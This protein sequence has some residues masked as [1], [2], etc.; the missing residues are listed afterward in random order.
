M[1]D[2]NLFATTLEFVDQGV[3]V[4]D[5]EL[6]VI[7]FNH[8]YMEL[9][10]FPTERFEQGEPLEKFIRFNAERG[11]Y[12]AGDIDDL[13]NARIG[14]ARTFES[15]TS[16]R[17]RPD[18]TVLKLCGKPVPGGGFIETYTDITDSRRNETA[19]RNNKFR[20]KDVAETSYDRLWETDREFRYT[21]ITDRRGAKTAP[22]IE[23][24]IGQT[25]WELAGVDVDDNEYW[26]R[27]YERLV[28]HRPF[29][30]FEYSVVDD[31]GKRQ[32]WRV[33]GI[34]YFDAAGNF[35]GYRGS[36]SDITARKDSEEKSEWLVNAFDYLSEAVAI[37]DKED[38]LVFCNQ[39]F[40]DRNRVVADLV[41]PGVKFESFLRAVVAEGLVLD[42]VGKEEE[43]IS[44]RLIKHQACGKPFEAVRRDRHVLIN[45]RRLPDGGIALISVNL[46]D[47]KKAEKSAQ[48]AKARMEEIIAIA[49]EA[50]ITCGG[51]MKIQMFNLGAERIFGYSAAEIIGQPMEI[52]MPESLRKRHNKHIE[53]FEK[54]PE[55]YRFMDQR[56][57]IAGL[58][59]D[60]SEFPASA[61]VS[62][63]EIGDD[64]I[65]TVMLHDITE[66]RRV[67]AERR[68]AL[69][70]AE[71][72][73]KAKSEFMASMSHELR[74]PLNSMLGFADM[75]SNQ[76]FGTIEE[77]K[78][79]DYAEN[80][81]VSGRH[82]LDLVNQILDIE[83]IEAGEYTLSKENIDVVELFG[84]CQKILK[85]RAMDRNIS[86]SFDASGNLQTLYADRSAI[87]QILINLITNAVKFTPEGGKVKVKASDSQD[88]L[89]FQISDTGVGI[90]KE[91]LLTIKDPFTRHESDP[92]K[93]QDGVGLGL[94]ISSSLVELHEGSL[95]INSEIQKGTTVTVGLPIQSDN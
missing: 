8:R 59:K 32:F 7:F 89:T 87:F 85:K 45:E 57:D 24:A 17:T 81:S 41:V 64:K 75:I 36:S 80:I 51:D 44:D 13:V 16:E 58:R 69:I 62:K 31:A 53:G 30:D 76:Y 74:T 38:R 67:E 55:S 11:E 1:K 83:R 92:H 95:E 3:C 18:G 61:S 72:A 84:D 65:Y 54:S 82:L 90:P 50:V 29:H 73:N 70:E 52:L 42:A 37:Y 47:L 48:S 9:L 15:I 2:S 4:V 40:R 14:Q 49:P 26:R 60:G 79:L 27:H 34:P 6:N 94:A 78:Y 43:W 39:S 56:D 88:R 77:N 33:S 12:G 28:S 10:G 66:R 35:S 25:R 5:A 68:A 21:S 23:S 71:K 20:L 22:V 93:P 46:S 63:L 19:L 86:L 91:K